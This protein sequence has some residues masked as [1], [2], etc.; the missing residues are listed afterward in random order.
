MLSLWDIIN[1]W[2]C[3]HVT[4]KYCCLM[5][6]LGISASVDVNGLECWVCIGDICELS[7]TDGSHRDNT[8]TCRESQACQVWVTSVKWQYMQ[9]YFSFKMLIPYAY[10]NHNIGKWIKLLFVICI[11]YLLLFANHNICKMIKL[12]YECNINYINIYQLLKKILLLCTDYAKFYTK[13]PNCDFM[14]LVPN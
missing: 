14:S 5:C 3:D 12:H 7:A 8:D 11:C 13:L 4:I 9:N 2:V 6:C 10:A 1:I